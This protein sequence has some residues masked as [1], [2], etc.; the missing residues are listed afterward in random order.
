MILEL[1]I[2]GLIA[3]KE[4]IALHV[5]TCLIPAFLLAGA[6][7]SF[8]SKEAIIKYLGSRVNKIK[9]FSIASA[10]SFFIAACSCTVIPIASGIYY[11]GSGIGTAFIFY[12]KERFNSIIA[13][14]SFAFEPQLY[15][16]KRAVFI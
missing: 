12:W 2:A 7:V 16:S 4:Y 15:Y 10:T 13:N 5:L 8:I 14:F 1:V 6:M 11:Q 9:S 3:L